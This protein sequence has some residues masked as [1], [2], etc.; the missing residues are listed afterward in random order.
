M[1]A[2]NVLITK[3]GILKL[4]DFG[5]SRAF[6]INKSGAANRCVKFIVINRILAYVFL[7]TTFSSF[8]INFLLIKQEKKYSVCLNTIYTIVG[9][10]IKIN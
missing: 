8:Y 6:S 4:A 9:L 7:K 2:A 5:L 10:N 3:T 1:K